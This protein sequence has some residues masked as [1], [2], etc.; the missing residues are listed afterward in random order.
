M[1]FCER[2]GGPLPVAPTDWPARYARKRFCS[3][4]CA[5]RSR[6]TSGYV[7]IK[8]ARGHVAEH[9]LVMEE[10]LGRRL[11]SDEVVHHRNGNKADNRIE[12]LELT[13]ARSHGLEHHPAKH[14]TTKACP[15]CGVTFTPHKTKRGRAVTCGRQC[16]TA[17]SIL[18]RHGEGSYRSWLQQHSPNWRLVLESERS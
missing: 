6:G 2:C 3:G 10:H 8:T 5:N 15:V 1:R 16:G 11:G 9:R 17:W 12:N 4:R 7:V 18:Q 14:P 13:D